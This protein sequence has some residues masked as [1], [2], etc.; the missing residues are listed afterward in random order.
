VRNNN[1]KAD[2]HGVGS[3]DLQADNIGATM[4]LSREAGANEAALSNLGPFTCDKW[5]SLVAIRGLLM[6]DGNSPHFGHLSGRFRVAIE[7]MSGRS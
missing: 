6:L 7:I 1:Q 3:E 2:D 5:N 4:A